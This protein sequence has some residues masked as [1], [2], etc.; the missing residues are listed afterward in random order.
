MNLYCNVSG[1]NW[2]AV[3][4]SGT[5]SSMKLIPMRPIWWIGEELSARG[6]TTNSTSCEKFPIRG[7]TI[8]CTCSSARVRKRVFPAWKS[9]IT[10]Y[11]GITSKCAIL[12]RTRFLPIGSESRRWWAQS[13]I[14]PKSWKN[15]RRRFWG[16]KRRFFHWKRSCS[17]IWF[18]HWRSIF[19]PYNSIPISLRGSTA[20][21]R[22][23]S[24]PWKTGI[25]VPK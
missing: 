15:T 24:R 8:C 11:S 22:S 7:K 20:C 25:F 5:E 10:T 18:L 14:S 17:M 9:G 6:W 3:R 23:W 21:C 16:Q 12:T 19:L 1:S 13:V 4:S 2:I